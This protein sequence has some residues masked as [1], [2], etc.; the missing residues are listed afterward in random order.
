MPLVIGTRYNIPFL[1]NRPGIGNYV[2]G[3]IY[4][5]DEKMMDILDNLED[6]Q[7]IYKRDEQKMNM[8][9]EIGYESRHC[10]SVTMHHQI[11][12]WIIL[13]FYR[14]VPCNVFLLDKYPPH[15]LDL[16]YISEYKNCAEH[17]YIQK[18]LRENVLNDSDFGPATAAAWLL[19]MP[20]WYF[21]GAK[22]VALRPL[23]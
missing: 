18:D 19:H 20:N 23:N 12:H 15:L 10:S 16:P 13:Y 4:E 22:I 5:V 7:R 17:P 11:S 6:C 1:I 3:E 8:G 9:I 21:C 14:E 2:T